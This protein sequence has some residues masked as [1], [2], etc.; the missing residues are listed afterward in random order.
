MAAFSQGQ[1]DKLATKGQALPDGSFPIRNSAD[2][3][4]AIHAFGRAKNPAAAKRHI[5]KRARALGLT[6]ELPEGW[7]SSASRLAKQIL[8]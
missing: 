4:N 3:K 1:R 6:S 5:I 7:I 8:S 2:L